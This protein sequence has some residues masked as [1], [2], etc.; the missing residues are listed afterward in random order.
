MKKGFLLIF[1]LLLFGSCGIIMDPSEYDLEENEVRVTFDV[2]DSVNEINIY[3][4]IWIGDTIYDSEEPETKVLK[5]GVEYEFEWDYSLGRVA[6]EIDYSIDYQ[7]VIIY[8]SD[9]LTEIDYKENPD[10]EKS[11]RY[12]FM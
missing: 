3:G 6:L 1:T 2:P 4:D 9:D 7:D 11:V 10:G 12:P 8:I 5:K